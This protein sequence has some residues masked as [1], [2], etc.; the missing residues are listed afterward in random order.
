MVD[1]AGGLDQ[2][3]SPG[4]R[5]KGLDP[6]AEEPHIGGDGGGDI[7]IAVVGGPAKRDAQIGQLDREPVV[8]LTL[9]GAVPQGHDVG[10]ASGEVPRVGG[11]NLGR[12]TAG[13]ELFLGELADRLQ[14]RKPGP[15]RRPVS[16][17]QRLAHQGVQQIQGGEVIIGTHDGA[18][19]VQ[20][21][22]TGEH[23]T[24]I[25]QRLFRLVEQL[26]GPGHRVAQCLMA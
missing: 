14:H 26:V 24:P 5:L 19:T 8:G 10:F 12:L 6:Q 25:Q 13:D 17:Q 1:R 23:R 16:D 15:P 9:A 4:Y 3:F 2:L 11:P 7:Q 22:S 18:S 20:V 21:E